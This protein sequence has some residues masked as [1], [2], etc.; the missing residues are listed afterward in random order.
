MLLKISL[1]SLTVLDK[2]EL[3]NV[4]IPQIVV[5]AFFGTVFVTEN[6]RLTGWFNLDV[7]VSNP[8]KEI[9]E[10][11]RCDYIPMIKESEDIPRRLK[12]IELLNPYL[13][14]IPV[15]NKN[16]K[17]LYAYAAEG[18]GR[19]NEL[20]QMYIDFDKREVLKWG[21]W[22]SFF[23]RKGVKNCVIWGVNVLSFKIDRICSSMTNLIVADYV[24]AAD[25]CQENIVDTAA[26]VQFI[27]QVYQFLNNADTEFIVVTDW[28][29]RNLAKHPQLQSKCVWIGDLLKHCMP[30]YDIEYLRMS[31]SKKLR[32][33][34]VFLK[35]VGIPNERDLG[36]G[37]KR[38][39]SSSE[40]NAWFADEVEGTLEDGSDFMRMRMEFSKSVKKTA[41]TRCLNDY[42][43]R[44]IHVKGGCR[45][46]VDQNFNAENTVYLI[47][48]CIVSGQFNK[49]EYTLGSFLQKKINEAGLS[50]KVICMAYPNEVD[51]IWYFRGLEKYALK[52]GDMVFWLETGQ[53]FLQYDISLKQ[54]YLDLLKEF[55]DTF[56]FDFL[57]HVGKAAA[58]R[59]A[60][61]LYEEL[62][63][64]Q[65]SVLEAEDL[66]VESADN[67]SCVAD[68]EL[69]KYLDKIKKESFLEK[70]KIGSIVMNCNPFTKGHRYLI[71][72][73]GR[74][75]DYLYIFVVEEDKSFFKFAD[76]IEMVRRGTRDMKNVMVF[77]SGRYMISSN[78]FSEYFTKDTITKKIDASVDV[79]LYGKY[80][81][82]SL[83]IKVR[84]LGK[85]P[86]DMITRQYNETL[87]SIL[88]GYGVDVVE[89]ERIEEQG[90][91]I[92]AS[93]VRRCLA[94]QDWK[95]IKQIVP[96]TTYD[97]LQEL[98]R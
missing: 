17:I 88:P 63:Q 11:V 4:D 22:R 81:A 7:Y 68:S 51:R 71:E 53:K 49:D 12:E 60:D 67:V 74:H 95:S 32:D 50:Y 57:M 61:V 1:S 10:L 79:E 55:G 9:Q 23:R 5:D 6:D 35:T 72:Y 33:Q 77:P 29:Y 90:E 76:R 89:I 15:V 66:T 96:D 37:I 86:L 21:G 73:A 98:Y 54:T 41:E 65:F 19:K 83:G 36:I 16:K 56:Y 30:Q 52:K 78:T 92:S 58:D 69:R 3:G 93:R 44:Y 87:K 27:D 38:R 97:Y 62:R 8:H 64:P 70:L 47:G 31:Y 26:E 40:W 80:I 84:F 46:V 42:E 75:V 28:R 25:I 48:P 18:E 24:E 34:G 91:V 82:P 43:S 85:E 59:I 14:V 39:T 20:R 94:D 2:R 45:Y 13:A